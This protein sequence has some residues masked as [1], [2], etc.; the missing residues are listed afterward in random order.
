MRSLLA[1]T[2]LCAVLPAAADNV[3]QVGDFSSGAPGGPPPAP[4]TSG[5]VKPNV[6]VVQENPP[7]E[8]GQW[9][10]LVDDSAQDAATLVQRFTE[11]PAGRLSFRLHVVKSDAAIWFLL[12]DKEVS[13]R[14]DTVF[15]FKINARGGLMVGQ[16][17]QKIPDTS[18]AKAHF[19]GGQTYDLYCDFK[20]AGD[21]FAIEIGQKDGAVCF[22][23]TTASAG[24]INALGIRTHGEEMGSDFYVTD[25]SLVS[26]P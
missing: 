20:P 12:G 7:G 11:I 13:G 17:R 16:D 19:P 4:W 24:S 21:G 25:L 1:M 6:T 22:R 23:G 8:S 26:E 2:F 5:K 3:L 15:S 10:H 14:G 9:I 18:G